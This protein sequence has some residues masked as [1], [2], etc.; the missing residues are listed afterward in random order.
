MHTRS[1]SSKVQSKI[2]TQGILALKMQA[3][4]VL[5]AI[6]LVFVF[7]SAEGFWLWNKPTESPPAANEINTPV[8][9][10]NIES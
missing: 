8:I 5:Q 7:C 10:G 2:A 6:A 3:R 1:K 4:N 9:I